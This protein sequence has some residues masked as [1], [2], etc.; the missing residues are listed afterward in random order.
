[1]K[2]QVAR[3]NKSISICIGRSGNQQQKSAAIQSEIFLL[4]LLFRNYVGLKGLFSK[5]NQGS[6]W[7]RN[8]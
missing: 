6:F 4:V 7:A 1:V 8:G 5:K 2:S 3:R